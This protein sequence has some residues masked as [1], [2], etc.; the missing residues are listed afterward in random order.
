M[1]LTEVLPLRISLLERIKEQITSSLTAFAFAPGVL[2]TTTPCLVHS[3]TLILLV[4]APARA[5]PKSDF[6][7][8]SSLKLK[9]LKIIPV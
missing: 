5:M 2:K 9:L 1:A 7:T 3:S 4:P 8:W 6:L